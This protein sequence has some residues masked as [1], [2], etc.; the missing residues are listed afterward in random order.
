MT[1]DLYTCYDH[2]HPKDSRFRVSQNN[3]E[4]SSILN[5]FSVDNVSTW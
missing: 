2:C 4:L 1:N 5:N 3:L